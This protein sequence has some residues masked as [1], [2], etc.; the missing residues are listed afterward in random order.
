MSEKKTS[1]ASVAMFVIL[2]FVGIRAC[3]SVNETIAANR[4]QT[5]QQ[6]QASSPKALSD[7]ERKALARE[8]KTISS[9][10]SCKNDKFKG[11]TFCDGKHSGTYIGAY[12]GYSD[13]MKDEIPNCYL[14]FK[15]VYQGDSWIFYDK[16]TV[17]FDG[18]RVNF[19][20]GQTP[21]R[22]NV[23]TTVFEEYDTS[24]K[25]EEIAL[26]TVIANA[27]KAEVRL[28]GKGTKDFTVK[29]GEKDTI[30]K[31]LR[32]YEICNLAK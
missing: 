24:A 9:S 29:K 25:A 27:K 30:K 22:D 28:E 31:M 14:R 2:G 17:L 20:V 7:E 3:N 21:D 1:K 12:I 15:I 8:F 5:M 13:K 19:R 26:L 6:A 18:E 4:P 11:T 23:G 16:A 32:A 10:L